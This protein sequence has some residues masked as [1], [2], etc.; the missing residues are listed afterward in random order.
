[1]NNAPKVIAL[2]AA[3]ACVGENYQDPTD[4]ERAHIQA[5]FEDAQFYR[6]I[7]LDLL[8]Q[9]DLTLERVQGGGVT[10][11]RAEAQEAA[12]FVFEQAR[13]YYEEERVLVAD[14]IYYTDFHGE[15]DTA[16]GVA[17]SKGTEAKEIVVFS[18]EFEE[19]WTDDLMLHEI[20]HNALNDGHKSNVRK[21]RDSVDIF[22]H[23]PEFIREVIESSDSAYVFTVLGMQKVMVCKRFKS[24]AD[25]HMENVERWA[26]MSEE[27]QV[28]S[29]LDHMERGL[30][31]YS[32]LSDEAAQRMREAMGIS[33]EEFR[34]IEGRYADMLSDYYIEKVLEHRRMYISERDAEVRSEQQREIGSYPNEMQGGFPR[35]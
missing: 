9:S 5:T 33:E 13:T 32:G 3:S 30:G 19:Q 7:Y 21:V 12:E 10:R 28:V 8:Q 14:V 16:L 24:A 34:G 4:E 27:E 35:R 25:Y 20:A 29:L 22:E 18:R 23:E 31:S 2:L 6:P 1:M 11:D 17:P 26:E 15:E